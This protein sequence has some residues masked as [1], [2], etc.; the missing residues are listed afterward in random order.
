M[1]WRGALQEA[2]DEGQER[3]IADQLF[4]K[5]VLK[6]FRKVCKMDKDTRRFKANL[7]RKIEKFYD[8]NSKR[9]ALYKIMKNVKCGHLNRIR[10]EF[11]I[12]I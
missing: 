1:E 7:Q 2:I 5:H 11:V 12:R 8:L 9:R 6:K 3:H 10:K 4:L